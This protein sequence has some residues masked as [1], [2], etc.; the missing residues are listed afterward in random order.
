MGYFVSSGR[1]APLGKIPKMP[2]TAWVES[3]SIYLFY[4]FLQQNRVIT[5]SIRNKMEKGTI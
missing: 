1:I 2:E 5:L 4:C 3:R